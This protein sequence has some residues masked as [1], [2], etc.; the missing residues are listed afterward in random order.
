MY[1]REFRKKKGLTQAELAE[2]LDIHEN[3]LRYWE[4][5]KFEPRSNDLLKIC[6]ALG[7][8]ESDLLNGPN[9]GKIKITISYDWNTYE[10]GEMNMSGNAFELNLGRFGAVGLHG[11][12]EFKSLSDIDEF[13]ARAKEQL[14][15][16]FEAQQKRGAIPPA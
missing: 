12:G 3:T 7:C 1:I 14:I 5:G 10:K 8:T 2:I 13:L 4:N 9:D 11:A 6:Q 15:I 16:A